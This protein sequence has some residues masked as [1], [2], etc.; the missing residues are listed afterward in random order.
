MLWMRNGDG[1]DFGLVI[2]AVLSRPTISV[3]IH[4]NHVVGNQ[5]RAALWGNVS[6]PHHLDPADQARDH[7]DT[8]WASL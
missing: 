1:K 8:S 2:T 6:L 3:H 7:P 4:K 5:Q